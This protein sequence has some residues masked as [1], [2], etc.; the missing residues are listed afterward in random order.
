MTHD[1]RSAKSSRPL[2]DTTAPSRSENWNRRDML[3]T[4]GVVL[5]GVAAWGILGSQRQRRQAVFIAK[6][7]R[8]DGS[9]A[10]T[11]RDGLT[12]VGVTR[13][14]CRGRRVLLKPNLVEPR[15]DRP[16]MT[17]HPAVVVAAAEV[18][19]GWDA[20]VVIGEAP[21]HV[22]DTEMALWESRLGEVLQ[23]SRWKFADLNYEPVRWFANRGRVS[24]L[25]GLHLPRSVVEADLLVSLPKLKTHHWVGM[26]AS[27][28]NLYGVLPG[29]KYGWPKNVLHHAGIPQSVVDIN[30]TV[31]RTLAIVDA[32]ECMEGDGPILGTPKT[33]GLLAM[34]ACLP[35]LDATL[36]RVMGL[37]PSHIPYLRLANGRLGPIADHQIEQ[38]GE[39][40]RRVADPFNL[41]DVSQFS[42]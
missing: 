6:E 21:G 34:G 31:P 38:R 37:N 1:H 7:Q 2:C 11:I 18:F 13:D 28:K 20:D 15:R 27:M 29:I 33:M 23:E 22:R 19:A 41:V 14:T 40:W 26:T 3:V 5:G 10:A 16:H 36:A 30:A 25:R 9:L 39:Q 35:A 42:G 24:P 32:I 12:A 4:G 17:T 8:Y